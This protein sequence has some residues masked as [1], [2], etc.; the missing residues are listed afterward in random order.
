MALNLL[1]ERSELPEVTVL[2]R[3]LLLLAFALAGLVLT[4]PAPASAHAALVNAAPEPGSVVATA[5]SEIVIRFT[6]T[7]AAVPARTQVLAPDGKRITG[8]VTATG[9]LLRITLRTADQ[10]LGTYLVSYRIISADSHPVG[11]AMTFSVGA[12]SARPTETDPTGIHPSV[13]AVQPMVRFF[14]YAG[15]TLIAGPAL[16]LAFLWPRRMS[17]RGPLLLVRAGFVLAGIG[18][19]GALWTQA[20]AVSGAAVWDVSLVELRDVVLSSFGVT[21]LARLAALIAASLL[22]GPLIS[23]AS[24]ARWRVAL[25]LAVGTAGL[26]TWPLTG[27]AS[28]AP[29]TA[30]VVAADV[31]HLASMAV[32]LGGLATLSAFLLPRAHPR[33]LAR[34]LPV[35]SRWAVLSVVWLAGGGVVQAVVQLGSFG[36]LFTTGYGR[37][38][39]AKVALLALVLL[40]ASFAHRFVTR[41]RVAT[42]GASRLRLTVGVEAAFTLVILGLSAVL[43]QT[44]PGRAVIAEREAP[45]PDGVSSTLTADLFTLQYYVYPVEIGEYNTVHGFT[46]TPEGKPLQAAEWTVTTRYLDEDLEPVSEPMLPLTPRNDAVGSLTFPL[47]GTYE[48][49]FRV[50]TTDIDQATVRTTIKVPQ[51]SATGPVGR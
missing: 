41:A 25:L 50:R 33:V 17:R 11:G 23:G 29:L 28:E 7:I 2:L 47:P 34:I 24:R 27:H 19:V 35:W 37:L 21:L 6:E 15:L 16:F 46:Y 48:V 12:P 18:T 42:A 31:V 32:W 10:P 45:T 43:V 38:L 26:V 44:D 36:A 40:A 5:P 30:A 39:L 13:Q 8:S 14:G 3:T 22:V 9:P 4:P 20:P 1:V 49:T 51:D